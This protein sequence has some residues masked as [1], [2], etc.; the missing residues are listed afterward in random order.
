MSFEGDQSPLGGESKSYSWSEAWFAAVTK[1]SVAT[2]EALIA[3]PSSA[4]NKAFLW[5][6]ISGVISYI[7]N[8]T[9][10]GLQL[11]RA[12]GLGFAL[13]C[14]TPMAFIFSVLGLAFFTGISHLIA[15]M[16]GGQGK[17]DQL[18]YANAAYQAPMAL[19][20]A[21]TGQIPYIYCLVIPLGL[22]NLVLGVIAIKAVHRFEWWQAVASSVAVILLLLVLA[23]I[24]V[25]GIL[26]LLGPTI[27]G[28]F[29]QIVDQLATPLPQ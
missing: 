7:I 29:S 21:V 2:F 25:I 28:V 11:E 26:A 10:G 6:A 4:R 13:V 14:G 23:A 8:L 9:F 24:L 19:I 15:K 27:G 22:Y 16:L 1:P 17:Y 18:L 3:D 12:G 20:I 5:I